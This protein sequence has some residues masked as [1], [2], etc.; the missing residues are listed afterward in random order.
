MTSE[1]EGK[2]KS[3]SDFIK[4]FKEACKW[5]LHSITSCAVQ[6]Y[7]PSNAMLN[8]DF[9]KQVLSGEKH[10]L[11]LKQVKFINVPVY[12]ELA[13]KRIYPLCQGEPQLM[14]YFPDKLPQ[15]R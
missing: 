6:L 5:S 2:F 7:V 4:Y 11:E 14:N 13:V 15:G 3:K 1:L 12:D 10:L 8:K 9:L